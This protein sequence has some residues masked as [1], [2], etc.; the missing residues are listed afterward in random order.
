MGRRIGIASIDGVLINEHLGRSR[1]FYII[2]LEPDGSSAVFERRPVTPLCRCGAHSEEGM[3]EV[4]AALKDCDAVLAAKI[5]PGARRYF[6]ER[7][8]A[9]FE[10]PLAIEEAVR[11]LAAYYAGTKGNPS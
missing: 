2:D 4:F 6:E 1:W 7:G 11:K 3:A 9:V 5:G 10:G 8:V